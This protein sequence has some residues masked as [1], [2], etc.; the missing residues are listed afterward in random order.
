MQK[1]TSFEHREKILLGG[2][3]VLEKGRELMGK[4]SP[5]DLSTVR[6]YKGSV[7]LKRESWGNAGRQVKTQSK[8]G[9]AGGWD[10]GQR[11]KS[12]R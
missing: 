1:D 8:R 10:Y 7:V 3:K 4:K 2:K 11:E 6:A 5:N 12:R 9:A